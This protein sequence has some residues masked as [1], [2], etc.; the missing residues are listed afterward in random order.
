MRRQ[1]LQRTNVNIYFASLVFLFSKLI[2][3]ED[4][5]DTLS[6][7]V[8]PI[9]LCINSTTNLSILSSVDLSINCPIVIPIN[10]NFRL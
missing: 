6:D 7:V 3:V 2:E 8:P 1:L 9:D 10:P 4:K 5:T